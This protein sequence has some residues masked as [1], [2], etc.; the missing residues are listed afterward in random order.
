VRL[1]FM[2]R[3]PPTPNNGG[4]GLR[5]AFSGSF[6]TPPLLGVGGPLLYEK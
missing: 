6:L 2:I 1:K 5:E 4:S 3:G